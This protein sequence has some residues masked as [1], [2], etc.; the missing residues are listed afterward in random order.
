M[1][2]VIAEAEVCP[3]PNR[4]P[5]APP[6]QCEVGVPDFVVLAPEAMG[7]SSPPTDISFLA[8]GRLMVTNQ[9]EIAIGD[10]M[11]WETYHSTTQNQGYVLGQVIADTD[12][13]L[14]ACF[15]DSFVRID[16][17]AD[18]RWNCSTAAEWPQKVPSSNRVFATASAWYWFGDGIVSWKPGQ[19]PRVIH[20]NDAN[21]RLFSIG[22]A[23]YISDATSGKLNRID[24]DSDQT[25]PVPIADT[26]AATG[27]I[28]SVE[29]SPGIALVATGQNGL[30]LFDGK[31]RTPYKVAT[32]IKHTMRVNDLCQVAGDCFAAAVDTLGIVIFDRN[33]K[34]V[35][36]LDRSL[37]HRLGR[38]SRLLYSGEGVIW[39]LLNNGIVRLAFP[40]SYSDYST[41]IPTGL[42]YALTVR[43]QGRLWMKSHGRI[44]Y[45]QYTPDGRLLRFEEDTPE[46]ADGGVA[47]MGVIDDRLLASRDDGIFEYTPP[48]GWKR[49][50]Q[51][52]V[53][54]R[55]NTAP[56][57]ADG[58]L[59]AARNE[60]GWLRPTNDGFNA[61]R[62]P[63]PELGSVYNNFL[64][65]DGS[66]W[67]ELGMS[68]TAR[69]TPTPGQPTVQIFCPEEGCPTGWINSF[70]L[71]GVA[72]H[73]AGG[74][75]ATYDPASRRLIEDTNLF[76]KYP[77]LHGS[78]GRPIK[79][80]IGRIWCSKEGSLQMIDTRLGDSTPSRVMLPTFGAFG[81][82][83]EDNGVLWLQEGRRLMRYDPNTISQPPTHPRALITSVLV[84]AT[85]RYMAIPG[86]NLGSLPFTENTL[87]FRFCAPGN[88]FGGTTNFEVRLQTSSDAGDHWT[89][90]GAVGSASFNHLKEGIYTFHVRPLRN[91]KTGEEAKVSFVIRP[92]WYRTTLAIT[93]YA[94]IGLTF[95]C[96]IAWV[97][98]YLERR[99]KRRLAL[100][101]DARTAELAQQVEKTTEKTS[102]LAAS[103]ER[104][105]VLNTQLEERVVLRTAELANSNQAL[106]QARI[107][108][109]EADRAKSAFLAN[110][111]HEIRTPMNGV[112][113]MGHLLLTTPL[114]P[115]QRDFVD[116]LIHSGESL[117]TILND[118]L[119]FSK[120]EAGQL[121]LESI[122]FSPIE[123]IERAADLQAANARKKNLELVL[124]IDPATPA[125][126]R[127][128]PVR[129]RQI[130]LN[131]IGNAIKFTEFGMV[132]IR[133]APAHSPTEGWSL[134]FE[135]EDTGI[136]ISP[137]AQRN[138]F[139]RFVQ[140]DTS[141]TRK[142]G[143]TGLGLAICRRLVELMHG[144]IGV[145][146][147][148]GHGST[149]WFVAQFGT[150]TGTLPAPTKIG[151]LQQHRLLIVDDNPTN[152][153]YFQ[154]LL[155]SWQVPNST[156]E[157]VE[158][159]LQTQRRAIADGQ[160]YDM[161]VI[162]HHM[163]DADGL[164]LAKYF[165]DDP[166]LGRPTMVLISSSGERMTPEE[167]HEF[168]LAACEFK[169][170]PATRFRELLQRALGTPQLSVVSAPSKTPAL[171]SA[172]TNGVSLRI[173]VAEDNRV[174]QKVALQYLKN[175]GHAAKIANNGQ[176]AID[177]LRLHPFDLVLMDVQM[178][179]LDGLEATRRI[180]AAQTA[181]ENGFDR[182][183]RIVAMTANAMG[184]DR[185]MCL[186]AGMDD[187]VPKPL[188]PESIQSLLKKHLKPVAGIP[189]PAES[190]ATS[191]T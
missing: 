39:A 185:E 70:I 9:H 57:T 79:D 98:S 41:M 11:R 124:D 8:D 105:R 123:Q 46:E 27:I 158:S 184:G 183:I 100:L 16:F 37:D 142:F 146:S 165:R 103:E 191:A 89:S 67:L 140:A 111:S 91:G 50:N 28:S 139:K 182:E 54:A 120:I 101:V 122:D 137:E 102:A 163:P 135:V 132:T 97:L 71:D 138:L 171:P 155:Q 116:T 107:Q 61:V 88:P 110:M 32:E 113:G 55:I 161:L 169:P 47:H 94:I 109:E 189:D 78:W 179:V 157:S 73:N 6:G 144:D 49:V 52:I 48:H 21:Q 160:P 151:N 104:Y 136:G 159:A 172:G 131:L 29:Y 75:I 4:I 1:A 22:Q 82:T 141:T 35:Q 25:I 81:I 33:G 133:V 166:S 5:A 114:N 7:L 66:V 168:G 90:M 36:V 10:G 3:D 148:H 14:Y 127:G 13:K 176:E 45:G 72:R 53:A 177:E 92:P 85:D 188:T 64:D 18:A 187:H 190:G 154:R 65:G 121:S 74:K 24:P 147:E 170:I 134:R 44:F 181:K 38:V 175:A 19:T 186:D 31:T 23:V 43:H 77:G 17:T 34:I 42:A 178:P 12:G 20:N 93:L 129:I 68:R 145:T 167:M 83:C 59:Y 63:V 40:S 96:L 126:V 174:N 86:P 150:A 149:F 112:I 76:K 87:S 84:A 180:R 60:V 2:S 156:A 99:E 51:G 143:G 117:M 56:P 115:E 26:S 125:L 80:P 164:M 119:D 15:A 58:W 69:I 130:L 30:Q 118:I 108:A 62:F 128:D 162:D 173:L 95:V 153:K 152:R 106:N